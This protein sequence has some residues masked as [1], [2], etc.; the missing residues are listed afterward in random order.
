MTSCD[1]TATMRWN[2]RADA[3]MDDEIDHR[4]VYA[5][6]C[7]V[8]S[9]R[10]GQSH[11]IVEH[12][13]N[14]AQQSRLGGHQSNHATLPTRPIGRRCRAGNDLE[15]LRGVPYQRR[16][17]TYIRSPSTSSVACTRW[18][19]MMMSFE[20]LRVKTSILFAGK[21]SDWVKSCITS[22]YSWVLGCCCLVDIAVSHRM[23]YSWVA[24]SR[25]RPMTY[26]T[27]CPFVPHARVHDSW[28]ECHSLWG[29]ELM[30][31]EVMIL[32]DYLMIMYNGRTAINGWGLRY[33][34]IAC[35]RDAAAA[36]S[37]APMRLDLLSSVKR[38]N[39]FSVLKDH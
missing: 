34:L 36:I 38:V 6:A 8:S 16:K 15:D 22:A 23:H 21:R 37:R 25:R 29:Q 24:L 12:V 19:P 18:V 26:V 5:F 9:D 27:F 28:M 39:W 11:L 4:R 10:W 7:Q 33:Y 31:I 1:M 13:V 32:D 20:S 3:V 30:M 17:G 2:Q 14:A 35:S